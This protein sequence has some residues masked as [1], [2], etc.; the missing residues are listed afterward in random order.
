MSPGKEQGRHLTLSGL[1]LGKSSFG[2]R[3]ELR[4]QEAGDP[5]KSTHPVPARTAP[6][7]GG[8]ASLCPFRD[9]DLLSPPPSFQFSDVS[10]GKREILNCRIFQGRHTFEM[11]NSV[12]S[13]CGGELGFGRSSLTCHIPEPLCGWSGALLHLREG[14]QGPLSWGT[15]PS[16]RQS[17]SKGIN[18]GKCSEENNKGRVI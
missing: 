15:C 5:P 2:M 16:M 3:P 7:Q 1:S 6:F 4:E 12:G 9:H 13:G 10:V 11:P 18:S 8:S 17:I 14:R